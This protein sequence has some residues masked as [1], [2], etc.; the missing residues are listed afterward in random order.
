[1]ERTAFVVATFC[2]EDCVHEHSDR[3]AETLK[4]WH[5]KGWQVV[6]ADTR[7]SAWTANAHAAAAYFTTTIVLERPN[8]E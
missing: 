2:R 5:K 8:K 7:V 6:S 3:V 4:L 1:V